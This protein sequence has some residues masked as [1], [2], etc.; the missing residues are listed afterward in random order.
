M[1]DAISI[2]RRCSF[3][4][5]IL[6]L[7]RDMLP[8]AWSI[9]IVLFAL[10]LAYIDRQQ[11]AADRNLS[12]QFNDPAICTYR[13][14]AWVAWLT[15]LESPSLSVQRIPFARSMQLEATRRSWRLC[16]DSDS[17][18]SVMSAILV[19]EIIGSC[20]LPV[21]LF[22]LLQ[23]KILYV[24]FFIVLMSLVGWRFVLWHYVREHYTHPTHFGAVKQ[25]RVKTYVLYLPQ[26]QGPAFTR[27][28]WRGYEVY[29]DARMVKQLPQNALETL[30][31]HEQGHIARGHT[32]V[33]FYLRLV[34]Y[35]VVLGALLSLIVFPTQLAQATGPIAALGALLFIVLLVAPEAT[36]MSL[37]MSWEKAAD[38]WAA[39]YVGQQAI[40]ALRVGLRTNTYY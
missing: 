21:F 9:A 25:K 31:A 38:A 18:P 10:G 17:S 32:D 29:L 1:I 11:S 36:S 22:I 12:F 8:N 13:V 7:L 16:E 27:R 19:S 20:V 35:I 40:N 37:R 28:T 5:S 26:K 6:L 33:E 14:P 30:Q 34:R 23:G 3:F 39:E 15:L 24:L 4:L 2:V